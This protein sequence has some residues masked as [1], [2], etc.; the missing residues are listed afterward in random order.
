MTTLETQISLLELNKGLRHGQT[1]RGLD[2]VEQININNNIEMRAL[3][4][5]PLEIQEFKNNY[6]GAIH[7]EY[8]MN[9]PSC[10][11]MPNNDYEQTSTSRETRSG[12]NPTTSMSSS[13]SSVV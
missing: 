4:K 9:N 11:M 2:L 5:S 3:K 8:K 1:K 10:E 12:S 7:V 13:F 6:K